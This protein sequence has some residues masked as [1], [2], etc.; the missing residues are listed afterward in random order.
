MYMN[1]GYSRHGD[2][3]EEMKQELRKL[4]EQAPDEKTRKSILEMMNKL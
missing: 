1:D 3:K 2:D 4:M